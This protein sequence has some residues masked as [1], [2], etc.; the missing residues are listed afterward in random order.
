M[1]SREGSAE[2]GLSRVFWRTASAP[3]VSAFPRERVVPGV[4]GLRRVLGPVTLE[5]D[6]GVT[7][8]FTSA[9]GGTGVAA[10]AV[11]RRAREAAVCRRGRGA[12]A[13][14][15][16]TVSFSG[17]VFLFISPCDV[18]VDAFFIVV[19]G[20]KGDHPKFLCVPPPV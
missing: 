16:A 7:L 2:A 10:G 4:A 9:A 17:L 13:S 18:F 14:G 19:T 20:M 8:A 11:A 15:E 6:S 12:A 3:P 1:A 5:V